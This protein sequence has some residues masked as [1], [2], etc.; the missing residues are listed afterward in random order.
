MEFAK[1][2]TILAIIILSPVTSLASSCIA[3]EAN[4]NVALSD[5]DFVFV[6]ELSSADLSVSGLVRGV[7]EVVDVIKGKSPKDLP[8]ETLVDYG[9]ACGRE[10]RRGARYIVFAT[11]AASSVVLSHNTRLVN[12]SNYVNAWVSRILDGS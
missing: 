1:I 7:F 8:F 12:S 10:V 5:A 9:S 11:A 6:G 3:P 2:A 4:L